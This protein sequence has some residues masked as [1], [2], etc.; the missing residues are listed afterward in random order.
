MSMKK[1]DYLLLVD[2]LE[3]KLP[4]PSK[5]E[6]ARTRWIVDYAS[7]LQFLNSE[8]GQIDK[9]IYDE[10]AKEPS[11]S[12]ISGNEK[13]KAEYNWR[14]Q[15][16]HIKNSLVLLR[17]W[18]E[19]RFKYGSMA[20]RTNS[21]KREPSWFY[22]ANGK[23]AWVLICGKFFLITDPK[24]S[25]KNFGVHLLDLLS[26]PSREGVVLK[27]QL[28]RRLSEQQVSYGGK[29]D[30]FSQAIKTINKKVDI[31]PNGREFIQ[32]KASGGC[33]VNEEYLHEIAKLP[34]SQV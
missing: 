9:V 28:T 2:D 29:S 15:C 6:L 21:V 34:L 7:L 14:E 13:M 17:D 12:L 11:T 31:S 27:E 24:Q 23:D 10:C 26:V 3:K 18:I 1:E 16:V 22:Y 20:T 5:G 25:R 33:C 4:K 30:P 32:V 19:R 8:L